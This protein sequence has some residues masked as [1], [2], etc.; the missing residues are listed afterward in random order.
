MGGATTMGQQEKQM[1]DASYE[2]R[3]NRMRQQEQQYLSNTDQQR[4]E[5]ET[6]AQRRVQTVHRQQLHYQQTINA[7]RPRYVQETAKARAPQPG[8]HVQHA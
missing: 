5:K 3:L 8:L 1:K 6:L 4:I 7:G 2:I